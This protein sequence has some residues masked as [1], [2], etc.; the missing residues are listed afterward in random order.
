MGAERRGDRPAAHQSP[1]SWL[2]LD[3]P[4]A[5]GEGGDVREGRRVEMSIGKAYRGAS[6]RMSSASAQPACEAA[7]E[8]R[9]AAPWVSRLPA[10][11]ERACQQLGVRSTRHIR[12]VPAPISSGEEQAR[13]CGFK[14]RKRQCTGRDWSFYTSHDAGSMALDAKNRIE[15]S[16]AI[17]HPPP[18]SRCQQKLPGPEP[19]LRG[20]GLKVDPSSW[21]MDDQD[22]CRHCRA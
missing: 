20:S 3:E 4:G 17:V 22:R 13:G 10:R 12:N 2:C 15:P 14:G 21:S 18:G 8:P 16:G 11:H 7:W 9:S 19:S 6:F 5:R 1:E